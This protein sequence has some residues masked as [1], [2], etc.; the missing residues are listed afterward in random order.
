LRPVRASSRLSDIDRLRV[1]KTPSPPQRPTWPSPGAVL[2]TGT[3][4]RRGLRVRTAFEY[5]TYRRP[6]K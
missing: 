4:V 3:L 6:I 2:A 5:S 1:V